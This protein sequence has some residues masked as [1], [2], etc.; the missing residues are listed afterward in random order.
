M[1]FLWL[2]G[3]DQNHLTLENRKKVTVIM[4]VLGL[5]AAT[6]SLSGV[7]AQNDMRP[8]AFRQPN[9]DTVRHLRV[10]ENARDKVYPPAPEPG[11]PKTF[12]VWRPL[13]REL[14]E[15]VGTR[16]FPPRCILIPFARSNA[17]ASGGLRRM[18]TCHRPLTSGEH[19]RI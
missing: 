9:P 17:T 12:D 10:G 13:F 4:R 18:P 5:L 7:T 19:N 1:N 2:L 3:S 16:I 11:A 6:L 15:K 8:E 14:Y